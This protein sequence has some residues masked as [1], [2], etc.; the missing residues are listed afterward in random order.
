M[1]TEQ[2]FQNQFFNDGILLA[3][4]D[5]YACTVIARQKY[6]DYLRELEREQKEQASL[7]KSD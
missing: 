5:D 3:E 6:L 4:T 1:D 7:R 2:H